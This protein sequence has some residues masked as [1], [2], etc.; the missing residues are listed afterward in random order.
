M[1]VR[2]HT[3]MQTVNCGWVVSANARGSSVELGIQSKL[4]RALHA[5]A[6]QVDQWLDFNTGM[7]A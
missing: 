2:I 4:E 6:G 5:V 3:F 1:K 7:L